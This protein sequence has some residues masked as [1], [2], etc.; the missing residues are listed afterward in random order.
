M[1]LLAV[2]KDKVRAHVIQYFH[3][4]FGDPISSFH[5]DT[6]VRKAY[7]YTAAAWSQLANVF[8]KLSWMRQLE[9]MLAPTEMLALKTVDDLTN[10]IWGK[11]NKVISVASLSTRFA[12]SSI[13]KFA[14]PKP[15]SKTRKT[16]K[17]GKTNR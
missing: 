10:A 4:V 3:D 2:S 12:A 8:N 13:K 11:L 7:S 9:V 17:R 15:K 5:P 16:T 6:D 1:D 14:G